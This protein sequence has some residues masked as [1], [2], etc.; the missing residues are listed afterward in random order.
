MNIE[1][2]QNPRP[3]LERASAM[4]VAG[5]VV[6]GDQMLLV[7]QP[8]PEGPGTV[9]ALPGGRVEPGEV[10][11]EAIVREIYEETGAWARLRGLL[12]V[13]QLVNPTNIRRDMGEIPKPGQTATVFIFLLAADPGEISGEGDPDKEIAAVEL[14]SFECGQ[15]RLSEHPFPFMRRLSTEAVGGLRAGSTETRMLAY[16]RNERG[17]DH[18]VGSSERTVD[19]AARS[20]RP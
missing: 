3:D 12:C 19:V 15:D 17:E 18:I 13:G 5:V 20:G 14:V 2:V 4:I 11:T 6:S 16:R 10:L 1:I 8:G 7:R 9:W